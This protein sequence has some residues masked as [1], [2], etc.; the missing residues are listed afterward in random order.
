MPGWAAAMTV[1]NREAYADDNVRA[2]GFD[3]WLPKVNDRPLFPGYL[4]INIVD[5]WLPSG[6]RGVRCILQG[7]LRSWDVQTIAEW[8]EEGLPPRYTRGQRLLVTGGPFRDN[9]VIYDGQPA[10][11]RADV[12]L[13]MLGRTDVS[14]TLNEADLV[15][16]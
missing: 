4:L 8:C 9:Y 16:A 10:V 5:R 13:R 12:L 15:E 11:K 1:P 14:L 7:F 3:S 6:T 2:L